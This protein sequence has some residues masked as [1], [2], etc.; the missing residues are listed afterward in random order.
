MG[1]LFGLF[2]NNYGLAAFY[3]RSKAPAEEWEF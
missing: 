1:L 2:F 3:F